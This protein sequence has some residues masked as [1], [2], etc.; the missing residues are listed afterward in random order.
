[1][2]SP[3]TLAIWGT[4]RLRSC[5]LEPLRRPLLSVVTRQGHR[6][7][8]G[9]LL[10]LAGS[11]LGSGVDDHPWLLL[12]DDGVWCNAR[13]LSSLFFNCGI[14]ITRHLPHRF[15]RAMG[16]ESEGVAQTPDPCGTATIGVVPALLVQGVLP[17]LSARVLEADP[18]CGASES[19]R[20]SDA[21]SDDVWYN[22][23]RLSSLFLN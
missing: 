9:Q 7:S 18:G 11:S 4:S 5:S 12:V 16:V 1:V 23:R 17:R 6:G 20:S 2:G 22:A 10:V 19:A 8:S 15:S 21:S 14:L 3:E 13:R